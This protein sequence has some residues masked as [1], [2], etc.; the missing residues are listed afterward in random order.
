MF[1]H[2]QMMLTF[3][4]GTFQT[5]LIFRHVTT[6]IELG[7]FPFVMSLLLIAVTGAFLGLAEVMVIGSLVDAFRHRRQRGKL[8]RNEVRALMKAARFQR[9]LRSLVI[10]PARP[11][12]TSQEEALAGLKRITGEDFGFDV[13]RWREW[14]EKHPEVSGMWPIEEFDQST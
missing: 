12:M 7:W 2:A 13:Q 1:S 9:N 14:G 11:G 3:G 8:W 6:N 10:G 5:A 4:L